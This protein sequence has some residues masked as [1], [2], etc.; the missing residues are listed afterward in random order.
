MYY[1]H[2]RLKSLNLWVSERERMQM[3]TAGCSR[4]DLTAKRHPFFS[5]LP[6][7]TSNYTFQRSHESELVSE[8]LL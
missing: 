8:M 5:G 7:E 1:L 4:H 6:P 2:R 3:I